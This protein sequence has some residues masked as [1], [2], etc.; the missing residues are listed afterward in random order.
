MMRDLPGEVRG[1]QEAVSDLQ[2]RWLK[3]ST[4]CARV[5]MH[6]H[7]TDD[8]IDNPVVGESAVTTFVTNDPDTGK[9]KTLKP[10]TA[11]ILLE[12]YV[13]IVGV[14]VVTHY[15]PQVAHLAIS[16]PTGIKGSFI[17]DCL[18]NG[19]IYVASDHAATAIKMSRAR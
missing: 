19:S 15:S 13:A 16:A 2:G 11:H 5:K 1:P 6:T 14:R 17:P 4:D 7:E 9:D 3:V 12:R 8:V 18:K 10:P